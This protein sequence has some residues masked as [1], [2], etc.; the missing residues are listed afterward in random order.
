MASWT[1]W[2]ANRA[3]L[4]AA[5]YTVISGAENASYP[6]S[7]CL[8]EDRQT[9]GKPNTTADTI[10]RL[11]LGAAYSIDGVALQGH[12]LGTQTATFTLKYS[13]TDNSADAWGDLTTCGAFVPSSDN[14]NCIRTLD[15]AATKRYWWYG[16]TGQDAVVE[17]AEI[18]LFDVIRTMTRAPS[19]GLDRVR[20]L[21]VANSETLGGSQRRAK[22]A[23]PK[24]SWSVPW[25]LLG[26]TGDYSYLWSDIISY[27]DSY[28][29][30][31]ITDQYYDADNYKPG[32]MV[33]LDQDAIHGR[34]NKR[35]L[36]DTNIELVEA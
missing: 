6:L 11:D 19:L 9:V 33:Y 17:I 8:D 26:R 14:P 20:Q 4:A 21:H 2:L 7:N 31:W 3:P 29:P 35:D 36:Y 18:A 30:F 34:V 27:T 28:R 22:L 16:I 1:L 13:A 23:E 25:S 15:P 5:A 12:T 10:V 24:W 32:Y